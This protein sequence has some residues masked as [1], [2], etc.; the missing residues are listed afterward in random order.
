MF[1]HSNDCK[2][3]RLVARSIMAAFALALVGAI[4]APRALADNAAIVTSNGPVKGISIFGVQGYLGIPYA[5]PPVGDLRWMPPVPSGRFPGGVFH[6]NQFGNICIQEKNYFFPDGGGAE[7]CLTL[8]VFTP[9]I[10]KNSDNKKAVPVMVWIHPG[11]FTTG[12]SFLYD[13]SPMV[14]AGNVIVVTINY[15]IGLLGFFAHQAIDAE[16]HTNGN[17]G[18]MDQQLALKWVNDNIAAFG[19]D[20]HRITIFGENSGGVSV[21]ANLA[22]P[23]AAGLFEGAIAESGAFLE[24]QPYFNFVVSLSDGETVGVPG[25]APSGDS[26]ATA[27]GCPGTTA[28]T[29]ACLR[30]LPASAVIALNPSSSIYPLVDGTILT[31]TPTEAF[32]SGEFNQVPVIS[33]GNHD[34]WRSFVAEQYDF[35][36]HPLVTNADYDDAVLALWGTPLN[37]FVEFLYPLSNY[38]G[39]PGLALGASGTDGLWACPERNSVRSLSQFVPTYAYEFTDENAPDL[40]EPVALATFPLGS[41]NIAQEQFLF[42]RDERFFGFN[43]LTPAEQS[44]SAAMVGYWTQFATTGNPNSASEPAWPAYTSGTDEFQSLVPPTPVTEPT[45]AFDADH[46]CSFFWNVI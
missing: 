40:F 38:G 13:P 44:L 14:L 20:P 10:K 23:T 18:L 16:G 32:A 9:N 25:Q 37:F 45:G 42:D 17:Y 4:S 39:S 12:G 41:F 30:G 11:G 35:L 1:A 31:K 26:V 21:Y 15:R 46:L 33:G 7:D 8:N 24:F 19:G 5:V 29:A 22:S 43:P 36:G 28:A 3:S 27:L 6:A 2:L 34:E